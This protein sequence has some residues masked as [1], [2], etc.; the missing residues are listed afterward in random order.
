MGIT[1]F[2]C[3]WIPINTHYKAI[4]LNIPNT[5]TKRFQGVRTLVG[6]GVKPHEKR[7]REEKNELNGAKKT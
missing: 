5:K 3:I 4:Y 2:F 7:Q 6:C 1:N